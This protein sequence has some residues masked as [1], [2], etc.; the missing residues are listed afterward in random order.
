[1]R[2][3]KA[4]VLVIFDCCHAGGFGGHKV[5]SGRSNFEFIAACGV[6]EKAALPGET[7]FTNALMWAL[8]ELKTGLQ[9][10][11]M[12]KSLVDKIKTCPS[13]AKDQKPELRRR[14]YHADGTVWI[15]PLD[16]PKLEL[17]SESKAE[18]REVD[19]EYIDLRLSFYRRVKPEDAGSIAK[20]LSRLVQDEKDFAAKHIDLINVSDPVSKYA[21][22]WKD[23]T[24]EGR[25]RKN[26]SV[27]LQ[28]DGMISPTTLLI[29]VAG[30]KTMYYSKKLFLLM[31]QQIHHHFFNNNTKASIPSRSQHLTTFVCFSSVG[32][33][34]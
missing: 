21:K 17:Q 12:S 24:A 10:P 31:L 28:T 16:T 33:Q 2:G 22:I 7:S 26:S 4:D 18:R 15:A 23:T 11:F 3:T 29:G 5:R 9:Y 27:S 20:H 30:R 19:H 32:Y 25:K 1:M 13:L 34:N 6:D 14:D 8:K